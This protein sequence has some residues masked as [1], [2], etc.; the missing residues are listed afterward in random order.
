MKI[1]AALTRCKKKNQKISWLK[2]D[3]PPIWILKV[4][5][6]IEERSTLLQKAFSLSYVKMTLLNA[7]TKNS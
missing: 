3:F 1:F 5:D 4:I 6:S 7:N 2:K